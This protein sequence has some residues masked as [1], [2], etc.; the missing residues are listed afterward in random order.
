[1]NYKAYARMLYL[2]IPPSLALLGVG[3]TGLLFAEGK[4]GVTF[5][6]GGAMVHAFTCEAVE[7]LT[8]GGA[9]VLGTG[10]F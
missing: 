4:A 2:N 9:A 6:G 5:G 3:A 10:A 1:M 7:A 8:C